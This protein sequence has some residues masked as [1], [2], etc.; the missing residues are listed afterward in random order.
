MALN[1]QKRA[2]ILALAAT[3]SG[4]I[5]LLIGERVLVSNEGLA[6]LFT[7]LG[8]LALG[9]A[10]VERVWALR[11]G[12][13]DRRPAAR[14]FL[15]LSL[16]GVLALVL[17]GVSTTRGRELFHLAKPQLEGRD[18]A[19]AVLTIAWIALMIAN[20]LPSLFGELAR[21]SMHRAEKV[22]SRRVFAAVAAGLSLGAALLYGG[23]FTYAADKADKNVDFSYFRVSRPSESTKRMV[24]S[25][26]EP[27]EVLVFIPPT[28]EV[29]SEVLKYLTDLRAGRA[30]KLTVSTHDFLGEPD[31]AK[32]H[33]LTK[34]GVLVLVRG[35]ASQKLDI[36]V[37][38]EKSRHLL[39]KLDGEFQKVLIKAMRDRRTAYFTVGHGELNEDTDKRNAR[40]AEGV[41][42]LV[43]T[44]N[45]QIKTLGLAD[46]LGTEVPKDATAVLVLGPTSRLTDSEVA[47]L[48]KYAEDGGKLLLALDPDAKADL[49]PLAAIVGLSWKPKLVL[50]EVPQARMQGTSADKK[51]LVAATFSSHASVSTLSKAGRNAPVLFA[52]AT[53]LDK[54]VDADK[55][56][57]VDFNI[58]SAPLAFTDENDNFELDSGSEKQGVL[59][60][61][62]AVTRKLGEGKDAKELRAFVLGDADVFS[63]FWFMQDRNNQ[64]MFIEA[65]R[66]L[67]GDESFSG[68]IQSEEDVAMVHTKADDQAY[69]YGTILGGPSLVLGL[70]LFVM[71]RRRS[72]MTPVA[73]GGVAK[74]ARKKKPERPSS[75]KTEPEEV[76]KPAT[77]ETPAA[78]DEGG[79]A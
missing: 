20:V 17:Y 68:E 73:K 30:D 19:G 33:K 57:L 71:M 16:S 78:S 66:W 35:K 59:N 41:R 2:D 31:L 10:L 6:K 75:P 65:L 79:E 69:F 11:Q 60:L 1:Q 14:V 23:L 15:A 42:Q 32:E 61:A 70:G 54:L 28:T 63:D 51:L 55:S 56:L 44:Q 34:D 37:D 40:T 48:H 3:L 53:A 47:T 29:R 26:S 27:L 64:L 77:S 46:G 7:A 72:P 21:F 45:Y 76:A 8:A 43:E 9:G 50:N 38:E 4:W 52:G 62:A 49:A 24:E 58:K 25:L 13:E 39:K 12:T 18:N 36:G 5:F 74:T 67:G 22:E